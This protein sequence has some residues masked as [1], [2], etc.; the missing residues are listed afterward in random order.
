MLWR[1]KILLEPITLILFR[2]IF[3]SIWIIIV[4]LSYMYDS[5]KLFTIMEFLAM[6]F[7]VALIIMVW[8]TAVG[9]FLVR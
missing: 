3:M 6:T 4:I 5:K 9:R 8:A 2:Y 7:L 1:R